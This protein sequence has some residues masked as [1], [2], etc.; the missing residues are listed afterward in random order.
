M[1]RA[2]L[3]SVQAL[4][5]E[6]SCTHLAGLLSG[7]SGLTYGFETAQHLQNRRCCRQPACPCCVG[8]F[9]RGRGR[10]QP[11][12]MSFPVGRMRESTRDPRPGTHL[13]LACLAM[14]ICSDFALFLYRSGP[15]RR[16]DPCVAAACAVRAASLVP[17]GGLNCLQWGLGV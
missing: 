4:L 1:G 9:A 10:A 8:V 2:Q 14:E 5:V 16:T 15:N 13:V 3:Y 6:S 17:A 11:V 7:F 12:P